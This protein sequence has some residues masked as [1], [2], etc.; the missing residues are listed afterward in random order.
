M[1]RRN[2]LKN[3]SAAGISVTAMGFAAC[4]NNTPV[5]VK[6]T[7]VT[8]SVDFALNEIT[9]DSLQEKMKSGTYTSKAVTQLYLDRIQ[10]IDKAGPRLNAIIE[11]NPDA[12]SIA[13]AMDAER[14]NGKVRGPL[15][16][17]PVLIKDNIDTADK[18][19][20]TAGALALEG[21]I[22][23]KDAFIVGKL[24]EA[25][26]VLL[27]KTNLSEW[28]N[29]RSTSSCSGW[30]S[31]GGQTKCPYIL[32]HNPC[33]S[34]SGSGVAI[35][36]NLCVVAIGTETDGSITCPAS[37]NGLVGIKPTVGLLSR[38]GII[39]ISST[40]DTAGPLA[41]TVKDAVILLSALT[42]ED[43]E[44]AVTAT[45]HGKTHPDYTKFLDA[46]GLKGKNIGIDRSKKSINHHLNALL[47]E[48][49]EV[50]KKQGANII[51]I[52]Y[53]SKI[54]KLGK[55]E[56]EIMQ[57]E[58]KAGVNNYLANANHKIKSLKDVIEFNKSNEEKA[59]PYFKQE[60]LE[61]SEKKTGLQSKEYTEAL[62]KGRDACR[63]II[64]AVIAK[65]KLDAIA[66][67]TM[68]PAC[69][70]DVVYGDRWGND[71]LTQPAAMSGYPH[72]SLPC[73][74]CYNLPVGLS[75]FSGAY[76]EPQLISIAY[77][78]EQVTKK[79]TAPAF[80][81]SFLD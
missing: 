29:F 56:I 25:G 80:I 11:I 39:P 59:M 64:D 30:S 35:A 13:E 53:A 55:F 45:S 31:R 79:R 22:A 75:F 23:K 3:S 72:I 20:T 62:S 33:G 49:I 74:M 18:M 63:K 15:H 27:G 38:S 54:D 60:Q 1:N 70:I 48:A 52:E 4:N 78:Y 66:G 12:L 32:D 76:T 69:S 19:Q 36:A 40:Q 65:H 51:E 46:A 34:S 58:F 8:E 26:A 16:G 68:G 7:P 47:D 43:N 61:L 9:I 67:I 28:A 24:R 2:F 71:F 57:Q 10:Q 5:T 14:K 42:G 6:E 77:A 81:K 73:G 17:I 37:V 50:L 21:N 41:R 44:D